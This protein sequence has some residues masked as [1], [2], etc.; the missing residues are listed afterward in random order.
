MMTGI[1]TTS[2][3]FT[4]YVTPK[5]VFSFIAKAV[6]IQEVILSGIGLVKL[7]K[8]FQFVQA[9]L[10]IRNDCNRDK[11]SKLSEVRIDVDPDMSNT[12]FVLKVELKINTHFLIFQISF[13]HTKNEHFYTGYHFERSWF[14]L[15][16]LAIIHE[17]VIYSPEDFQFKPLCKVKSTSPLPF[18][19]IDFSR[20]KDGKAI[21]ALPLTG[22]PY[23]YFALTATFKE[24]SVIAK[25]LTVSIST[26]NLVSTYKSVESSNCKPSMPLEYTVLYALLQ[27]TREVR[28]S[29]NLKV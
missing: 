3:L 4:E 5:P 17:I 24:F 10:H 15:C 8:L 14:G 9:R 1:S 29:M 13:I 16:D 22:L 18:M 12:Y 7:I 25:S 21:V 2:C 28:L 6:I 11:F 26:L 23:V 19:S 20:Y 27:H